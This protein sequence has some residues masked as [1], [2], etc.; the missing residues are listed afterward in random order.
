MSREARI[1]RVR[2]ALR[3]PGIRP[4]DIAQTLGVLL[5]NLLC[6]CASTVEADGAIDELSAGLK[7]SVHS[8]FDET[9]RG[10]TLH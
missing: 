7:T 1:E 9:G 6:N 10:R 3:E 4:V 2:A 8:Y 5:V